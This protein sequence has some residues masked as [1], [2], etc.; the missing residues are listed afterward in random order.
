MVDTPHGDFPP[1]STEQLARFLLESAKQDP[2]LLGRSH[3]PLVNDLQGDG[4]DLPVAREFQQALRLP[5]PYVLGRDEERDL[6]DLVSIAVES[7]QQAEDAVRQAREAT[8]AVRR[9][10]ALYAGLGVLGLLAGMAAI[11]DNHLHGTSSAT[12]APPEAATV[13]AVAE[14]PQ[15]GVQPPIGTASITPTPLAQTPQSVGQT[16]QFVAETPHSTASPTPPVAAQP[17]SGE[18][19]IAPTGTDSRLVP[20]GAGAASP[21]IPAASEQ[22]VARPIVPPPTVPAPIVPPVYHAPTAYNAATRPPR[23]P[24]RYYASAPTRRIV[25][26]P[27]FVAL[28]RDF[29]ALFRAFPPHS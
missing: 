6:E 14:P 25:A 4:W 19:T 10:M 23:P 3:P 12:V 13:A 29:S 20:Q 5:A 27:F 7:A 26:P 22:P 16:P 9:G 1:P 21:V 17:Q 28:R 18:A 15:G 2:A 24:V 8:G 11:A